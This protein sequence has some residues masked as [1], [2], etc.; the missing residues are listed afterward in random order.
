MLVTEHFMM[1][2][3]WTAAD[4]ILAFEDF[5]VVIVKITVFWD[6]VPCSL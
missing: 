1:I 3:W 4:M 6:L 5:M 2:F